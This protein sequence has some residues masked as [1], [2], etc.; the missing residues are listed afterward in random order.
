MR[1]TMTV[2]EIM[3]ASGD[4]DVYALL[5][6]GIGEV[7][8]ITGCRTG[9]GIMLTYTDGFPSDSRSSILYADPTERY[10]VRVY[11]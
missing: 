5:G 10:V 8:I 11:S 3:Q 6:D 1:I 9:D 4:S 7:F 2:E